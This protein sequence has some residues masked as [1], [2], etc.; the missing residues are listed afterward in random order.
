MPDAITYCASIRLIHS[1]N[2]SICDS[3]NETDID[4]DDNNKCPLLRQWVRPLLR[5][6]STNKSTG[7]LVT[8]VQLSY[9]DSE[10]TG[11]AIPALAP[12]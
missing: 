5:L 8:Y 1:I 4:D 2:R 11:S 3:G 12:S 7:F 10:S 6:T 9:S